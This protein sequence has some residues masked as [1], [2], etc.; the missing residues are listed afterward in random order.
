MRRQRK[1][2]IPSGQTTDEW[3][4]AKHLT[5]T[6]LHTLLLPSYTYYITGAGKNPVAQD[7][8]ISVVPRGEKTECWTI[9]QVDS[10]QLG[11]DGIRAS[12]F[13]DKRF[14]AAQLDPQLMRGS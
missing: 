3:S 6:L 9:C 1:Q 2:H 12:R 4:R 11:P 10:L 14:P 5:P 8:G 13:T 7:L